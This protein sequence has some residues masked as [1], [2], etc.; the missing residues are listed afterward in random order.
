[1]TF[2]KPLLAKDPIKDCTYPLFSCLMSQ[3]CMKVYFKYSCLND[4]Y[5]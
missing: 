3:I 1:M 4:I 5:I 2:S